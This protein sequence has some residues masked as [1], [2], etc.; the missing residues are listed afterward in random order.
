MKRIIGTSLF[1]VS[2][3]ALIFFIY[4]GA[5]FVWLICLIILA[6]MG[7]VFVRSSSRNFI[8]AIENEINDNEEKLKVTGEKIKVEFDSCDFKDSSYMNEIIDERA[9]R[10]VGTVNLDMGKVLSKDYVGQS[11]LIYHHTTGGKTEEF[12][13]AFPCGAE[14]LKFYVLNNSVTLYVD[15]FDRSRY[16]F[17]LKI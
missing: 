12:K 9:F 8:A 11:I 13:Q 5:S 6:I 16:F 10:G 2:T 4:Q 7:L 14:S 17:D 1:V 3:I 15:A